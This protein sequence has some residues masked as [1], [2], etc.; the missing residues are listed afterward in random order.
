MKKNSAQ[1]EI[2][3]ADVLVVFSVL[4][5]ALIVLLTHENSDW[6]FGRFVRHINWSL[7]IPHS[8]PSGWWT[9]V[10]FHFSS[11]VQR[12]QC[13]KNSRGQVTNDTEVEKVIVSYFFFFMRLE[14]SEQG[15]WAYEH[16]HDV[17]WPLRKVLEC[18]RRERKK[19]RYSIK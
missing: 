7:Q 13:C 2:F 11:P 18:D 17:N 3:D 14:I 16:T 5:V 19:E 4:V 15:D 10:S 12:N 6:K 8:K 9:C 1:G